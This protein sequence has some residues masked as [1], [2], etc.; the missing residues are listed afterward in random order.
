MHNCVVEQERDGATS[1]LREKKSILRNGKEGREREAEDTC[2]SRAHMHER[3]HS[4]Y[5][6]PVDVKN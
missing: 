6:P 5:Q 1:R 3:V 4:G 2:D